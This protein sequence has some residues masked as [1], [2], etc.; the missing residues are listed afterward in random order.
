MTQLETAYAL[1]INRG[2][3]ALPLRTIEQLDNRS[4]ECGCRPYLVPD[5]NVSILSL[6]KKDEES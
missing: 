6:A 3:I 1:A 4:L 2:V 5:L